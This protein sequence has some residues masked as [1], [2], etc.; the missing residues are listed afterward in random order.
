MIK[1]KDKRYEAIFNRLKELNIEQLHRIKYALENKK[2]CYDNYNYDEKTNKYSP[3]AVA[4]N[5][6]LNVINPTDYIITQELNKLYIPVNTLK[7]VSGIFYT[8]YRSKNL[9]S[10]LNFLIY[11]D[12]DYVENILNHHSRISYDVPYNEL[13]LI[14]QSIIKKHALITSSFLELEIDSYYHSNKFTKIYNYIDN[15]E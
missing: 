5:L 8:R 11:N 2:L 7:G 12:I 9:L 3:L 14:K 13:D 15:L 10:L 6:D 1:F 4:H